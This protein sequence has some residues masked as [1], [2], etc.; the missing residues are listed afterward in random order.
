MKKGRIFALVLAVIMLLSF[1]VPMFSAFATSDPTVPSGGSGI[2]DII[3]ERHEI[4]EG[5]STIF[6]SEIK[7]DQPYYIVTY[8]KNMTN[9]DITDAVVILNSCDFFMED[10]N[11][12][13]KVIGTIPANSTVTTGFY[14]GYKGSGS[15]YSITVDGKQTTQVED[16]DN[17]G[18][19][20][21]VVSQVTE[22][23]SIYVENTVTGAVDEPVS[24]SVPKVIISQYSTGEDSIQAGKDFNFSF[25]L[26]NTSKDVT[27]SNMVVTVSSLDG[28]IVP[29]EGS[30]S[31][32]I[33][34]ITP[35]A[36][37]ALNLPLSVKPDAE[38]KS[39]ELTLTISY[40]DQSA[41][42]HSSTEKLSIK[43]IQPQKLEVQNIYGTDYGDVGMQTSIGMQFVNTGKAPLLNL[44]LEIKG[45]FTVPD[46][47][48]Y[49][50]NFQSGSFNSADMAVIP[51]SSG[52]LEGE[53][54]FT[55]ENDAGEVSEVSHPFTMDVMEG[56][57][58]GDDM[59]GP[60]IGIG[61]DGE[62]WGPDGVYPPVEE[63]G[64]IPIYFIIGGAVVI[65]IIGFI[66]FKKIKAKKEME[67]LDEE[68]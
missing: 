57:T 49:I 16:A 59:G 5:G 30:N 52:L 60:D 33:E 35:G 9:T 44:T 22:S 32:Y 63:G 53:I 31:F 28:V 54:L 45:D 34:S 41:S 7:E 18:T 4:F 29:A 20:I 46:G 17:P 58:G 39:Y 50:G 43:V 14:V 6:A 48:Y 51:N 3:I 42:P 23:M 67:L 10:N 64:G 21:D 40:E 37:R 15:N 2:P 25:T 65:L 47:V 66:I 24:A 55:F 36:S 68:D 27:V 56:Y 8:I 62:I 26:K 13:N 12:N 38:T 11:P 1:L 19:M 61:P